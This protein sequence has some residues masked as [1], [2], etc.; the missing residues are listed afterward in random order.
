MLKIDRLNPV[1]SRQASLDV[2]SIPTFFRLLQTLL[3][4]L[5]PSPNSPFSFLYLLFPPLIPFNPIY[6]STPLSPTHS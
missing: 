4:F 5:H 6:P 3:N 1:S 2:L